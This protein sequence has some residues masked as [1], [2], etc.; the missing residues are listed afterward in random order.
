MSPPSRVR[1]LAPSL[2]RSA[3]HCRCTL[4]GETDDLASLANLDE[5]ILLAELHARY[6][7]N[8][9]YVSRGVDP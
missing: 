4:K 3:L 6:K 2:P 9:I 8:T 1:A 7:T 5:K